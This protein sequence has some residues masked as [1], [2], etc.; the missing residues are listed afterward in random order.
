M[1]D[2]LLFGLLVEVFQRLARVLL[3]L[4]KIVVTTVSDTLELLLTEGEVVFNVV[5]LLRV[6]RTLAIGDIED[7]E[8]FL[9]KANLFVESEA[10]GEPCVG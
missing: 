1:W 2:E 5:S 8:L 7:M 6:M 4:T 9:I 3:V 10:V